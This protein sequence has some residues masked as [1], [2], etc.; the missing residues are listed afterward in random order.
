M[1]EEINRVLTDSISD[2]LFVSEESGMVNL[3]REGKTEDQLFMVGNVMIDSLINNLPKIEA[4]G[5]L[6]AFGVQKNGYFLVTLH[7]P[8]N[9]DD[10]ATLSKII[11][12]LNKYARSHKIIFPVHPRTRTNMAGFGLSGELSPEIRL[13]DPIGY[14]DFIKLLKNAT[15]ILT[16]IGGIQEES[17]FLG[18]PCITMRENTERPVTIEM[19]TNHLIGTDVGKIENAITGILRDGGKTGAIPPFWD[20]KTAERVC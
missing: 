15:L 4:S 11:S 16:D 6:S 5:A 12:I 7:R 18:V 19:G 2:F 14:L 8:S 1:P 13:C 9:V 20:G 3:R 10:K 17:T